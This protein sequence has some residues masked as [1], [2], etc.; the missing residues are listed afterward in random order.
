MI[1]GLICIHELVVIDGETIRLNK[2]TSFMTWRRII[3]ILSPGGE[4]SPPALPMR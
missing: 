1:P 4:T 2:K 3:N